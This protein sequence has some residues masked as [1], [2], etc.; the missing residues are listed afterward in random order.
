M[1]GKLTWNYRIIMDN[2][3]EDPHEFWYAIHEVY[4]ID[5]QPIDYTVSQSS[6]FGDSIE[7]LNMIIADMKEA[8]N[9]PV[10]KKSEFPPMD[11]YR[12]AEWMKVREI[13]EKI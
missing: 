10:L 5:N 4:Y 2:T 12:R 8:F 13:A 6:I 7:D 9:H 1:S 11:D 3:T